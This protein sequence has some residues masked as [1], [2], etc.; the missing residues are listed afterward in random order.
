MLAVACSWCL[1]SHHSLTRFI[2][3][4]PS[5]R[6][7]SSIIIRLISFLYFIQCSSLQ[8]CSL[9]SISLPPSFF[10]KADSAVYQI[11][12]C[13]SFV[14]KFTVPLVLYPL[15]EILY[16]LSLF[17][18]YTYYLSFFLICPFSIVRDMNLVVFY[19]TCSIC[20]LLRGC[21]ISITAQRCWLKLIILIHISSS[22][23]VPL[24]TNLMQ[25]YPPPHWHD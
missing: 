16:F 20:I 25:G 23:Q 24:M 19:T 9:A 22:H 4:L 6:S 13:S 14:W 3:P 21:C 7:S 8:F 5:C 1:A 12:S 17:Q 2:N 11:L 15:H 10:C 18:V